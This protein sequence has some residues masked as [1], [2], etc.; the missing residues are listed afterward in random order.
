MAESGKQE[1]IR[2]IVVALIRGLR[3][4]IALLEKIMRGEPA[5]R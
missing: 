1:D 4:T 3:F 2:A 5:D